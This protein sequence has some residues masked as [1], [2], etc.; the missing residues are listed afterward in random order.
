MVDADASDCETGAYD[1]GFDFRRA[2][3]DLIRRLRQQ[4][5]SLGEERRVTLL[6]WAWV[7]SCLRRGRDGRIEFVIVH[8]DRGSGANSERPSPAQD[9]TSFI[10]QL[11]RTFRPL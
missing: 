7:G 1:L 11:S 5:T 4:H 8:F 3:G 10:V 2:L 6:R 9:P